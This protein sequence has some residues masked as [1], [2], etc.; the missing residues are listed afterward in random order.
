MSATQEKA[1]ALI[2]GWRDEM[3]AF[4]ETLVNME[5]G[6]PH[7]EDVDKVAAFLRDRIDSFGGKASI[8]QYPE[9][10]N[11]VAAVFGEGTDKAPVC[12]LGHFDTVFKH[13]TV[14]ERPFTI[15]DGKA[16]GPG[17]LDMKGGVTI[18]IFAARALKEAGFTDRQIKIVLAGDE[19]SLHPKSDMEDVFEANAKGSVAAFNFETGDI[20][21]S[22]VVGRKGSYSYK[23]EVKGVSV[24]AGREPEKGRSAVRELCHKVIE[25]EALSDYN[26]GMTFNV[27]VMQGGFVRNAVP[28]Y[29]CAEIDVR[30][31]K[32]SQLAYVEEKLTEIAAKTYIDGT[33]TTLSKGAGMAPME[34]L[35]GNDKLY[36][37]VK[38]TAA[39]IGQ[40]VSNP[41][42]SGGASDSAY[43]VRA[44]VP[45]I[46]Q[47]GVKGQWNHSDREYGV[48]ET[49][50]ERAKLAVACVL[51]LD[52][53]KAK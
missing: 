45:T 20:N 36:E 25:I 18:Q 19:E 28:D 7:K 23:M 41:I 26:G 8:L 21:N 2:D 46:D 52:D 1:F 17:V 48:V 30:I 15:K 29:A 9:A 10:G 38:A 37:L 40:E 5:S 32:N 42:V 16:Y 50:F 27:G 51:A 35:E 11:S 39:K 47:M 49:L 12:F 31:V 13:G 43:S 53:F 24:H 14:A 22:L 33:T 44:G 3:V 34:R 6:S 4:W